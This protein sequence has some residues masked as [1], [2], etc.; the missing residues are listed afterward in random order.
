MTKNVTVNTKALRKIKSN[1]VY[2]EQCFHYVKN[3]T[4]LQFYFNI[5]SFAININST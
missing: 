4:D 1:S 2:M 5:I 3:P